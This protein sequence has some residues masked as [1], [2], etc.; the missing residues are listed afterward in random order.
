MI[1]EYQGAVIKECQVLAP[2]AG[3]R[4]DGLI[5][6]KKDIDDL[7]YLRPSQVVDWVSHMQ[8]RFAP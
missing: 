8:T 5:L 2:L 6:G 4:I 1:L 7:R 3:L